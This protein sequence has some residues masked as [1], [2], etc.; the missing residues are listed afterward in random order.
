MPPPREVDIRPQHGLVVRV[1]P[2]CHAHGHVDS[3]AQTRRRLGRRCLA[4]RCLTRWCWRRWCWPWRGRAAVGWSSPFVR[5]RRRMPAA[6]PR[7]IVIVVALAPERP[8]PSGLGAPL[9]LAMWT[10]TPPQTGFFRQARRAWR[11]YVIVEA[12][13]LITGED[14]HAQTASMLEARGANRQRRLSFEPSRYQV[15]QGRIKV[16]AD[17]SLF[18]IWVGNGLTRPRPVASA[19]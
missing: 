13:A 11:P 19:R 4:R 3:I 18:H 10:P 12:S 6:R 16:R 17:P 14:C 7:R 9:L 1:E 2:P 15:G 5:R 8:F